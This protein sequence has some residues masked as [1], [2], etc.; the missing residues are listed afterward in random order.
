MKDRNVKRSLLKK[1][2]VKETGCRIQHTGW[3][4]NS[5]F[6]AMSL[7]TDNDRLHELWGSTLLL[8]GDYTNGD[9]ITQSDMELS[10]NIDEL[11][12]LLKRGE[13]RLT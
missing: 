4:C 7:K 12:R 2:L 1:L 9:L 10:T 11:I 8:R 5:C 3:P 6:H 13:R